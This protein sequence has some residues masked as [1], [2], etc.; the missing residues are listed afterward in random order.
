VQRR[1]E[2]QARRRP[3]AA[4]ERLVARNERVHGKI[5]LGMHHRKY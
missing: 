2:L 1:L 4:S 5:A 3:V